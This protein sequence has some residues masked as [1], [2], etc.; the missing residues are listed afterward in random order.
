MVYNSRSRFLPAKTTGSL[1]HYYA[2]YWFHMYCTGVP[3]KVANGCIVYKLIPSVTQFLLGPL[4][5]RQVHTL[6]VTSP[7]QSISLLDIYWYVIV[8][9]R[10]LS[11]NSWGSGKTI[12]SGAVRWPPLGHSAPVIQLLPWLHLSGH[13]VI[14]Q[15]SV[16]MVT[17]HV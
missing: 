8:R 5:L 14:T 6:P 2:L 3:I 9:W 17:W 12:D 7:W 1:R 10:E 11:I 16:T 13:H 15:P 4:S